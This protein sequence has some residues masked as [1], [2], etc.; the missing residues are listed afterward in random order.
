MKHHVLIVDD[1]EMIQ[2]MVAYLAKEGMDVRTTQVGINQD[3]GLLAS[4]QQNAQVAGNKAFANAS[5]SASNGD[6]LFFAKELA[7][8]VSD[9]G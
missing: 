4:G 7:H 8:A 6:Y 1:D 2:S 9:L 3:R 5:L